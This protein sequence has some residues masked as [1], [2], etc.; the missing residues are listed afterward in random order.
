M[1]FRVPY[2]GKFVDCKIVDEGYLPQH[3]PVFYGIRCAFGDTYE[4]FSENVSY[5]QMC[6]ER[7]HEALSGTYAK[8]M[9]S[10]FAV[11]YKDKEFHIIKNR[12]GLNEGTIKPIEE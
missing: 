1:I 6:E 8:L 10:E 7:I 11:I 2:S 3:G 5:Q 9:N 4:E 12:F